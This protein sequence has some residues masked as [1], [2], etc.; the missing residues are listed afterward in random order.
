MS[1]LPAFLLAMAPA[2][3]MLLQALVAMAP[4]P[5]ML[6]LVAMVLA[7]LMLALVASPQAYAQPQA[8]GQ[9]SRPY[10]LGERWGSSPQPWPP[11]RQPVERPR[12]LQ[13]WRAMGP[14]RSPLFLVGPSGVA[15]VPRP[16]RPELGR[17][18]QV[19]VA[20]HPY[21]CPEV[22]RASQVAGLEHQPGQAGPKLR[23]A[24]RCYSSV[25]ERRGSC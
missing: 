21:P 12:E 8:Y 15:P 24:A 20:A 13:R 9:S 18:S 3:L 2:S 4:A 14:P 19:V 1:G 10:Q 6:A 7:S 5:L 22:G 23:W 25:Y 11:R 16:C 17:A